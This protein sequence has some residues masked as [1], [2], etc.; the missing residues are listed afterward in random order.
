VPY[1]KPPEEK[2]IKRCR[3]DRV[4]SYAAAENRG[5]PNRPATNLALALS[6]ASTALLSNDLLTFVA[7]G[8]ID[9]IES[10]IYEPESKGARLVTNK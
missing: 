9:P 2:Y 1:V 7:S 8:I 10:M 6:K 4:V 5:C 3:N